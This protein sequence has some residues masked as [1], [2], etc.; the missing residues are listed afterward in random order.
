M[1]PQ[2]LL[3]FLAMQAQPGLSWFAR[4]HGPVRLGVLL[5]IPTRSAL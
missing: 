2:Q 5:A 4:L 3:C 1:L